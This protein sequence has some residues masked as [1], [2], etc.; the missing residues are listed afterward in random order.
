MVGEI[1]AGPPKVANA[2]GFVTL[3]VNDHESHGAGI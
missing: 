3:F 2:V 1:C